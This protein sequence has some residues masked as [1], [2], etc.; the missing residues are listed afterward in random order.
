ML[1]L[2]D[3]GSGSDSDVDDATPSPLAPAPVPFT[4]KPVPPV[5]RTALPSA[6]LLLNASTAGGLPSAASLFAGSGPGAIGEQ[7]MPST[8]HSRKRPAGGV[9]APVA[10]TIKQQRGPVVTQSAAMLPPQ[11]RGRSNT[12]TVDLEN[13]GLARKRNAAEKKPA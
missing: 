7:F 4:A 5:A 3:Y 6:A 13:M 9:N 2:V 12:T 11:L 1:G 8:V 10:S